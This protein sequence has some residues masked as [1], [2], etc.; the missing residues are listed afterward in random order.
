[1][2]TQFARAVVIHVK[3]DADSHVAHRHAIL[4]EYVIPAV[5]ALPGFKKGTWMNDG[6]GDGL[7]I[8][9]FDTEE[10]AKTAVG[11]LTSP[12]GPAVVSCHIYIVEIEA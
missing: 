4:D 7:C 12:R 11:P 2:E 10:N 1:M 6:A 8:V 9:V 3:I 5:K